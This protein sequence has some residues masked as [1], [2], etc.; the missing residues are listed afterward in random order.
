MVGK[1]WIFV[2]N[3]CFHCLSN[4]Q[5]YGIANWNWKDFFLV[6]ILTNLK[7]CRLKI[8]NLDKLIFINKI[9][10]NDPKLDYYLPFNL[11][12]LIETKTNVYLENKLEEYEGELEQDE[13]IIDM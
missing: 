5:D 11:I 10:P 13:L 9:W 6:E 3:C 12:K 7:R 1:T 8:D 4:P 2:F